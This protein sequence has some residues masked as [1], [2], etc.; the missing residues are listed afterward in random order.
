M[1]GK[2][3]FSFLRKGIISNL[4]D[5]LISMSKKIYG[6]LAENNSKIISQLKQIKAEVGIE[7]KEILLNKFKKQHPELY[8]VLLIEYM[9]LFKPQ[10]KPYWYKRKHGFFD[11]GFYY[12]GDDS[13]EGYLL[14]NKQNLNERTET[15]TLGII[16]YLHLK[17]DDEIL[18][19]PCGY[20]RHLRKLYDLGFERLSGLDACQSQI[21][22]ASNTLPKGVD[23]QVS[24]MNKMLYKNKFNAIINMFYSIGF[25]PKDKQIKKVFKKIYQALKPGGEFLI[26]T[27]VDPMIVSDSGRY[28]HNEYRH[29]KDNRLL[30]IHDEYD[31]KTKRMNGFWIIADHDYLVRKDYSMRI[32][33]KTDF[34]FFLNNAGFK[35]VNFYSDWENKSYDPKIGSEMMVIIAQK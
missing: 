31:K 18:D 16:N 11:D 2:K 8:R 35:V 19:I 23:L 24:E 6:L 7:Q 15:E 26:H 25:E 22:L 10:A 27:D 20:G 13:K 4:D 5:L 32:F 34:L 28:K 3:Q 9:S 17:I 29:L 12:T 33:S 21:E 1:Q 14:D 30:R